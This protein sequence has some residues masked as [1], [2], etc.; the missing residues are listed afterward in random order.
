MTGFQKEYCVLPILQV[1][2]AWMSGKI[3]IQTLH[4]TRVWTLTA[5]LGEEH[6]TVSAIKAYFIFM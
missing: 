1:G 3:S 6:V 4:F 5:N 2:R